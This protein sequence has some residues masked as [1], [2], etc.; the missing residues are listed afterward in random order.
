MGREIAIKV[1][2]GTGGVASGGEEVLAAFRDAAAVSGIEAAFQDR[3]SPRKVGCRGFCSKDVLVDVIID[4][5]KTTYMHVSPD[6]VERIFDEHIRNGNPVTEWTVE[7]EYHTFHNTQAKVVLS[8][9]GEID[10]EDINA[11]IKAGGYRAAEKAVTSMSS[12]EI[13]EIVK[14]SNLRGRGGAGFPTG[15]KWELGLRIT[16]DIKYVI[17][18]GD[19]GDPG[20]FM[21]RSV[22]EGDPHSVIEGMIIC[23]RATDSRKGY[24]YVRAEYPL[25]VHRL[26]MAI[27]Q[28]YGRGYLGKTIFGT[29]FNFDL[30]I[31]QGAGAF[32]CGEATALMRSIE[33]KRGMPTPKLWRSAEKGLWDKPTVL[34]NVETFANI[35]RIIING[36]D[37]YRKIGTDRSGG[38]KVFSLSGKVKNT[39]LIEVPLGTTLRKIIYEIGGGIEGGRSFKALQTGGP[40]G[41]CVPAEFL[42]T[43]VD[44]ES[45][46]Q[47]GSIMGSGGMVVLDET[48]CMVDTAKFFLQFTQSESCGKCVPCRIGTKRMLEILERITSGSGRD[49]DIELLE[50]LGQYIRATSLCGLG[51]TA[52]N[53]VLSTI[54]YFRSEYE[55]HIRD[56]KCPAA[57]CKDLI[58]Y[59]ILQ[60]VCVGCG[61]CKR[62][63]PA[64]AVRGTRKSPHRI[65]NEVCVKCGTC[66]DACKFRAITKA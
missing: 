53:P 10:P 16:S 54:R 50:E 14:A 48:S 38:T 47:V 25:A 46:A 35:P 12:Q 30:R 52:P 51:M 26:Q 41:G 45:L 62:V 4:G 37:W 22:M 8:N 42:D 28:C 11:Y 55:A 39:G 49:G 56:K 29:D 32:V 27:D 18:N 3:C 23:A 6:M 19:E 9:C 43:E 17:C 5:K 1:C 63:C 34:N 20:A 15:L 57:V 31:F 64:D 13:V 7:D 66:F 2:T 44:Y 65:D 58:T 33:G 40:S 59:S 21:D 61:A 24:I 60:D 36:A